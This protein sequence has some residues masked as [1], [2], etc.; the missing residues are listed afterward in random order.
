MGKRRKSGTERG[1][2]ESGPDT[3]SKVLS[4]GKY[5]KKKIGE[6]DAGGKKKGQGVKGEEKV[7]AED[8]VEKKRG[9][10]RLLRLMKKRR[11][12]T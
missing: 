8:T 2:E 9:L 1:A 3:W 4:F 12:G 11:N 10:T 5:H 6:G 7:K